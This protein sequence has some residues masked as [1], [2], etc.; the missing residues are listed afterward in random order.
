MKRYSRYRYILILFF[1][2]NLAGIFYFGNRML[3]NRIPDD[4]KI[5]V[6]ETGRFDFSL[7]IEAG[8]STENVDAI[9]VAQAKLD[10]NMIHFDLSDPFTIQSSKAG[11]YKI[12]LK[13]FGLI[14][15]KQVNLEVIK[16]IKVTPSGIPI[17]IY[18]KTDGIMVLGTGVIHSVDGLNYEPAL[19]ILKSGDYILAVND[20]QITNK[21]ELSKQIQESK[22]KD[23]R[24]KIRRGN[25]ETKVTVKPIKT[26]DGDYK[27]GTW[28]RN[29]TQGIGTLTYITE[30]K[31]FGAL[32]HG[33]TDVD[34]NLMMDVG[35]GAIYKADILQIQK[36]ER[37]TPG[38]LVGLINLAKSD[39]YGDIFKNTEQGIFGSMEKE[40]DR[41]TVMDPMPIAFKQEIKLGKASILCCI[42]KEI[43]Q[44]DIVIEKISLN[45]KNH[46]KGL[47]IRITDK[48]LL[49][50]T[51]GIVQG[52]SG[53]PIIQNDK[54]IG[55]VT[56]V[57]I[58]DSTKGYGIFIENMLQ[59]GE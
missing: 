1:L 13:L 38:E 29:D 14:K 37:G 46:S 45:T 26:V 7:P 6:N 27:I 2:I 12:N 33:I 25:V 8:I 56:H 42:D 35:E 36:G 55:A 50:K 53:S 57:F 40:S 21:E 16:S 48:E 34:T 5:A 11:K 49:S 43:K 17:G 18:V 47:V 23:I 10:Q 19:N 30:N 31:Q 28:I 20:E 3:D 4:I 52:M 51:N 58:Q 9:N 41:F 15:L 54:L 39:K 44:Y 24:I 59:N 22:G 32:G